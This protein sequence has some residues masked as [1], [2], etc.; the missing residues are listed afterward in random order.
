MMP[1]KHGAFNSIVTLY[2]LTF[3]IVFSKTL[4]PFQ[5]L[6]SVVYVITT[7]ITVAHHPI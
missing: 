6:L 3:K 7:D 2:M 4:F 5:C 1:Q